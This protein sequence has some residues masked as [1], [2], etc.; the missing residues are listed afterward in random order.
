MMD[1]ALQQ[2]QLSVSCAA[3]T[4]AGLAKHAAVGVGA[5]SDSG[6]DDLIP[7]D[8][9]S[10]SAP[11]QI[12]IASTTAFLAAGKFGL[13]PTVKNGTNA[14]C[15][16]QPRANSAGLITNDPSGDY[17]D[18]GPGASGLAQVVGQ[19][20]RIP[21]LGDLS[22]IRQQLSAAAVGSNSGAVSGPGAGAASAT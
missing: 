22:G 15:K 20:G 3:D 6:A 1:D 18:R 14:A 9:C 21:A 12:M 4:D 10:L 5:A 8:C 17:S 13:A 11:L 19:P 16:L 7:C 2:Q